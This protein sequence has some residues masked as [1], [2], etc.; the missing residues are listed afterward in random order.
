MWITPWVWPWMGPIVK[1][2][3]EAADSSSSFC[4]L[5]WELTTAEIHV[6]PQHAQGAVPNLPRAGENLHLTKE[7]HQEKNLWKSN[8][9]IT[10]SEPGYVFSIKNHCDPITPKDI[11]AHTHTESN[12]LTTKQLYS[13]TPARRGPWYCD[14][15]GIKW[16][17]RSLCC[18]TTSFQ[19]VQGLIS[20][21]STT[22]D[23]DRGSA[24]HSVL[25][26][27]VKTTVAVRE[28]E[29]FPPAINSSDLSSGSI[30][31]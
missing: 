2:G 25:Q 4:R 10:S 20:G 12:L 29:Q 21:R 13:I 30:V 16:W 28:T 18:V 17:R 7:Y 19:E 15:Q 3:G 22:E 31:E 23:T 1:E 5:W 26:Y 9:N 14:I 6:S 11:P 8:L 24:N 27:T